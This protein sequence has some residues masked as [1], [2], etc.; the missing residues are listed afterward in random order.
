MVWLN[1]WQCWSFHCSYL[2]DLPVLGAHHLLFQED[3]KE[4]VSN[5]KTF[6][7]VLIET[8]N[9]YTRGAEPTYLQIS[10][11]KEGTGRTFCFAARAQRTGAGALSPG[12]WGVGGARDGG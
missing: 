1:R 12:Y 6:I 2:S 9:I 4:S 5:S 3:Q 11:T 8:K 10:L 7:Q